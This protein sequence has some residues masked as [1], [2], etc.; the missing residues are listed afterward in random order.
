MDIDGAEYSALLGAKEI[1]CKYKP[2]LT[3]C[4]YHS[5]EDRFRI[6]ELIKSFVPEYKFYL[7]KSSPVYETILFCKV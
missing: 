7:K 3:I 1:I 2:K 5:F 6:P 4:I